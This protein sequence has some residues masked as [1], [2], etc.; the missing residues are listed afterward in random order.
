M[1]TA[2]DEK[3]Q[4]AQEISENQNLQFQPQIKPSTYIPPKISIFKKTLF[5][6]IK[7]FKLNYFLFLGCIFLILS[8]IIFNINYFNVISLSYLYP[9]LFAP[10]PHTYDTV[11]NK[12]ILRSVPY[13]SGIQAY[14]IEGNLQSV[15]KNIVT[16]NYKEK[17]IQLITNK[18]TQCLR[19][20]S[21][22]NSSVIFCSDLLNENNLGKKVFI[23]FSNS[24]DNTNI[25]QSIL[26]E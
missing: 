4:S 19:K 17:T 22:K 20:T 14:Q 9:K 13:D 1:D 15:Y 2:Q 6:L 16:V 10:L 18:D 3:K 7:L 26:I 12:A 11:A 23:T 25:I 5:L 8:L 21:Q 24:S